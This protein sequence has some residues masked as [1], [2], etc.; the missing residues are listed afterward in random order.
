MVWLS[1]DGIRTAVVDTRR[2]DISRI[3]AMTSEKIRV[4]SETDE[5]KVLAIL[6]NTLSKALE[7]LQKK[8]KMRIHTAHC[9]LSS[10]W[11]ISQT[12][13]ISYAAAKP[14]KI[15]PSFVEN[16]VEA[17]TRAFIESLFAGPDGRIFN[18]TLGI[19][20][21]FF[22]KALSV[23]EKKIMALTYNGYEV[24]DVPA[25]THAQTISA[26][27]YESVAGTEI[28][29]KVEAALHKHH[30][31]HTI[32]WHTTPVSV[33]SVIR[34]LD[35]AAH[36][37]LLIDVGNIVT[38]IGIIKKGVLRETITVPF[39]SKHCLDEVKKALNTTEEVALSMCRLEQEGKM[40]P[41]ST[42]KLEAARFKIGQK[43]KEYFD[44]AQKQMSEQFFLPT[45][46]FIRGEEPFLTFWDA[47]LREGDCVSFGSIHCPCVPV[48]IDEAFLTS[49]GV[50]SLKGEA[51]MYALA[52]FLDQSKG[53]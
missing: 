6:S 39:G 27:I 19:F 52:H 53:K 23:I 21:N 41:E 28:I 9:F 32:Y 37:Y 44:A 15:T 42:L 36:D 13:T 25:T 7:E 33:Y 4:Q 51:T 22:N 29:E 31:A 35:P 49:I 24:Q 48:K 2:S 17:D 14:E 11:F 26:T 45:S 16:L 20:E 38:D 50:A 1:G 5:K 43:W 47:M 18:Y 12:R 34:A 3:V 8:V 10:P 30:A 46:I 40:Q